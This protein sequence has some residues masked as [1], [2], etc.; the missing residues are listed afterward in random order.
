MIQLNNQ[1]E[2][3]ETISKELETLNTSGTKLIKDMIIVPINKS[4]L[5]IESVY[6]VMLNES[7]IPVL[8]KVIVASGNT[9]AIGDTLEAALVNLFSDANSVDL[10]FINTDNI[11]A[12]IDS[13]IR[14]NQNLNESLNAN[15]FEMIGKDITRLQAVINQLQVVRENELEL[16]KQQENVEDDSDD[17]KNENVV[18]N[19]VTNTSSKARMLNATNSISNTATTNSVR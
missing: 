17:N 16:E 19:E 11:D 18:G 6:Q 7:E 8:K 5:Y 3:D 9:V 4:L 13:V 15:D 14:A 2:Q 12:L 10:E 1:I